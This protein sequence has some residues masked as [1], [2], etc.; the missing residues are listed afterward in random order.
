[1]IWHSELLL[2]IVS[3]TLTTYTDI[4]PLTNLS[5]FVHC[6]HSCLVLHLKVFKHDNGVGGYYLT[7]VWDV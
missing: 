2:N 5:G 3:Y 6:I 4:L 1:M 7:I